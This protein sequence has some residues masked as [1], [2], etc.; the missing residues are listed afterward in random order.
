MTDE[1]LIAYLCN[2]LHETACQEVEAWYLASKDNQTLSEQ[3]CFTLFVGDRLQ[4]DT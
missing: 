1:T 4:T 3:L 2:T